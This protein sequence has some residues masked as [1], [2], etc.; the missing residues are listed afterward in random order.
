MQRDTGR[1]RD[2]VEP[3]FEQL[4]IHL[5]QSRL[6]E[7]G[8]PDQD[9]P[10]GNIERNA[11]QGLV[12]RRIGHAITPYPRLVAQRL[13]NRLSDR[14]GAVLG[15]VVLIDVEIAF[16]R[17]G[18]VDQRMARELLDHVIEKANPG[19]NRIGAGAIK[20]HFDRDIGLVSLASDTGNSV[21][22]C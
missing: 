16:D 11:A 2:R 22:R 21:V 14:N 4:G 20:V 3:V 10:A 19:R 1:L 17:A 18:N 7:R 12:H 13:G 15:G 8:L 9:R 6:A 5:A